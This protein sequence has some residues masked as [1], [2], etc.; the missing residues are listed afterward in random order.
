MVRLDDESVVLSR[1]DLFHTQKWTVLNV[2]ASWCAPC[3]E[4]HPLLM[5]W[6]SSK[7]VH[8][9]GLNYK[10][11]PSNANTFLKQLGNPYT[12]I[13]SDPKGRA[14]IDL[15]VYGVPETFLIDTNGVVRHKVMGALTSESLAEIEKMI[16]AQ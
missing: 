12:L 6:A 5:Q 16:V 1:A 13:G 4:E 7:R 15:G 3:R 11:S 8:L 10:D 9:V 2:F 14:G